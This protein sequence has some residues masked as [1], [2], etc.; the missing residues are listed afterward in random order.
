MTN[1]TDEFEQEFLDVAMDELGDDM[2][3][4]SPGSIPV[5]FKGDF[6]STL[7]IDQM[8]T[9]VHVDQDNVQCYESQILGVTRG[10]KITYKGETYIINHIIPDGTG[11]IKIILRLS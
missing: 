11:W 10:D 6:N 8:G 4:T 5:P 2:L 1:F 7:E 3:W 9:I